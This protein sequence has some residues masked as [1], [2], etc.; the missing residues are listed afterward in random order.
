[1]D[2]RTTVPPPDGTGAVVKKPRGRFPLTPINLRR[3]QNF[4][5]QKAKIRHG[6][7]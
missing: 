6:K 1:M 5:G 7:K 2:A 3:W 4:T